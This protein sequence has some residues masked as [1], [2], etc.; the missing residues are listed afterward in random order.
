M[1]TSKKNVTSWWKGLLACGCL[2]LSAMLFCAAGI[3]A[4]A[5]VQVQENSSFVIEADKMST[6]R[7]VYEIRV[8]IQN[9][10]KDWEGTVRV[11]VDEN[12]EAGAAYDVTISLPQGSEKQFVVK[13]PVNS[14]E[15]TNGAVQISLLDKREK[16]V[17]QKEFRGLLY[18]ETDALFMGILSDE[19]DA[20]T[21][22]D[23]GG[24]QIYYYGDDYPIKLTKLEQS[25]LADTL[26]SLDLL[27]IDT[28]NTSVLT[29][30][31][32]KA[33]ELWNYDG[34][35]LILGTGSYAED[36]L[37]G[38]E[39]YNAG[40]LNVSVANGQQGNQSSDYYS[41]DLENLAQ[42]P[43][44][45]ILDTKGNYMMQ[46]NSNA[47]AVY[48]GDGAV[49]I[50]PYSLT[51]LGKQG[52]D[53]FTY[54]GGDQEEFVLSM[55][56]EITSHANKRYDTSSSYHS[57]DSA[58]NRAYRMLG[59]MGSENSPL[60]FGI[61]K[62]II[63]M[64][65]IVAGPVL[66][67]ILKASKKRELYWILVPATALV[68]I[69]LVFLAG[70]GFEVVDTRAY[71]VTIKDLD[72]PGSRTSYLYC[73]NAHHKEWDLQLAQGY[74]Y[75]GDMWNDHYYY[76]VDEGDYYH[77]FKQEG[78]RISFGIKPDTNFEDSY[79][80][81][82]GNDGENS[83]TIVNGIVNLG[84]SGPEGTVTNSTNKD[85]LYYAVILNDTV[86]VYKDL[87]AGATHD[88]SKQTYL[89]GTSSYSNIWSGYIYDFLQDEMN[90]R[91]RKKEDISALA[92]L[93]VGIC[94]AYPESDANQC[95][96]IGVTEDWENVVDD[97]CSEISYG[98]L[99]TIMK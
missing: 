25:S 63:I 73:Y 87:P 1:K 67:L 36:V 50:L 97:R 7:D 2:V 19:Y 44:A 40:Y 95:V 48:M 41:Q 30:E 80:M 24:K 52:S 31:D 27:V 78:D 75:A 34:G 94:G 98:C 60:H 90:M 15:D 51:E 18:E 57:Y 3:E 79:F 43:F 38:F 58:A 54:I 56:E 91:N 5:D 22:L 72:R 59:I 13:V 68:G 17:A 42:V 47:M 55:L 61:L 84:W 11:Y 10:G 26:E 77:H 88:L 65:V 93:G 82:H 62:F 46:Y 92:A 49:G 6:D 29:D 53:Y 33:I 37:S 89:H 85:F 35:V 81:A 23:M 28:Y 32:L 96:I 39:R 69:V 64:Y 20:L 4:R 8:K 14:I 45:N 21:Y 71:T 86:Y 99:Y 16:E 74:E 83:G 66:Y 12:Y 9:T 76:D 70:R